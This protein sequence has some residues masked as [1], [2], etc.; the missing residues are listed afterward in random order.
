MEGARIATETDVH[1]IAEMAQRCRSETARQRRG[2]MLLLTGQ[3]SD[4]SPEAVLEEIRSPEHLVLVGT[5]DEVPVGFAVARLESLHDGSR[6]ARLHEI[7]V[8]PDARGVGV[9]GALMLGVLRWA[10]EQDCVGIDARVLPGDREAKNFFERHGLT[11]REIVVH[12]EVPSF[13]ELRILW[14]DEHDGPS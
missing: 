9:G 2:I 6:L 8:E 3:T 7:Y 1:V 5:Y 4:R 10:A 13:E 14:P 12:R 11:A